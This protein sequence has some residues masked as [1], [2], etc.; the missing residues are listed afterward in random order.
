MTLDRMCDLAVVSRAGFYR[1]QPEEDALDPDMELRDAIR[2]IA[3]E[4]PCYSRHRGKRI[5]G[6]ALQTHRVRE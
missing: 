6:R 4:F 2:K 3:L 1:F 5:Q